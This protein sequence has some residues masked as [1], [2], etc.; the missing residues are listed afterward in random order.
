[1]FA[2]ALLLAQVS[3]SALQMQSALQVQPADIATRRFVEVVDTPPPRRPHAV[4][5]SDAYYTRLKIH[6][7][8]S[9]T[10]LPLF[11]GEY[12]LGQNLIQHNTV[13]PSWVKPAHGA[14]A[15][16]LGVVFLSN[17]VTGVWNLVESRHDK[18]GRTLRWI[19]SLSML[20]ADAGFAATGLTAHGSRG[21]SANNDTHRNLAIGSMS[22]AV[23]STAIMW[24]RKDE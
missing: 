8:G 10:I 20:T 19:H 17:S 11:A 21:G 13:S 7:I 24:L 3:V 5:H 9:F 12:L 4:E 1:M 6:R 22:I 15:S 23:I 2:T 18:E 16:A 14:V